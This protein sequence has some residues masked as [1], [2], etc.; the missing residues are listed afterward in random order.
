[1]T[2]KDAIQGFENFSIRSLWSDDTDEGYFSIV[3]II[4]VLSESPN[5]RK[6]WSV[7]KTRLKKVGSE[8]ATNCCQQKMVVQKK[9]ALEI[10][11]LITFGRW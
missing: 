6:Y 4:A 8:L 7:L 11:M 2:K 9:Q 10:A 5:P 3:D 1:M